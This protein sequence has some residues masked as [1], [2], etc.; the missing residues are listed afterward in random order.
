MSIPP[1]L[2]L[3]RSDC[4]R[5]NRHPTPPRVYD[6]VVVAAGQSI[7]AVQNHTSQPSLLVLPGQR[8]VNRTA[9]PLIYNDPAGNTATASS[10]L[11]T[12]P[13]TGWASG[14]L[15][16]YRFDYIVSGTGLT[17]RIFPDQ[18]GSYVMRG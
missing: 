2:A 15:R 6:V 5:T 9:Q 11:T 7:I 4:S 16:E 1:S 18:V 17:T 10:Q 3:F 8:L 14:Y 13:A 12:D